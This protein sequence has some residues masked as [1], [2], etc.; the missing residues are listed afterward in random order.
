LRYIWKV[1][2]GRFRESKLAAY[3][4]PKISQNYIEHD[5]IDL[6]I[7]QVI[8]MLNLLQHRYHG[9]DMTK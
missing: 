6:Y 3:I 9:G 7:Y 8:V 5:N 1:I 4:H 2:T